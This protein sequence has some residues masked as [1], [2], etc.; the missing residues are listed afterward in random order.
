MYRI[1]TMYP[2]DPRAPFYNPGGELRPLARLHLVREALVPRGCDE[3]TLQAMVL[4][5]AENTQTVSRRQYTKT[6]L[7][8]S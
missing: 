2:E 4:E 6:F 8:F 7:F 3:D 1:T 5:E